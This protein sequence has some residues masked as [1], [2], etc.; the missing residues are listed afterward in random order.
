MLITKKSNICNEKRS[1]ISY[2]MV[3]LIVSVMSFCQC[4]TIITIGFTLCFPFFF[5][6]YIDTKSKEQVYNKIGYI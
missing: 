3:L 5:F 4:N 6:L 1:W 2:F